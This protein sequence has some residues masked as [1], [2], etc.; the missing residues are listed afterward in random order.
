MTSKE[1]GETEDEKLLERYRR[2]SDTD[3][4]APSDAVRAA[5]LAESRRMA[6]LL[7]RQG[8]GPAFD[9]SRPAANESR[10]RIPAFGTLG[11]AL[12]AALLIAPRYWQTPPSSKVAMTPRSAAD[13]ALASRQPAA[14]SMAPPSKPEAVAPAPRSE[15]LQEVVVTQPDR[16]RGNASAEA[17]AKNSAVPAKDIYRANAPAEVATPSNYT[18]MPEPAS[19]PLTASARTADSALYKS[20]DRLAAAPDAPSPARLQSAAE[21]GDVMQA[22]ALLDRGAVVD[23]RDAQGRTPL[24][25]AV[26][27][28]R[29]E[30]VRLL[31]QR[32]A[33]PNLTD[34]AGKTA[35]QLATDQNL[36]DIVTLLRGAGAR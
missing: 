35:L 29:L 9:T 33:S 26:A 17:S 20:A 12:L 3:S 23:V 27:Q 18:A 15:P 36:T 7:A 30:V 24:M 32:G 21:A 31:L 11:A 5:I 22:T 16:K 8:S 34:N 2:A 19:S 14:L 13:P 10:W 1:Y 4:T 28:G 6:D 25:L